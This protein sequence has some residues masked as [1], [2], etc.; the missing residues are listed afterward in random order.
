MLQ[1]NGVC[2]DYSKSKVERF[3]RRSV[4]TINRS[5]SSTATRRCH[6]WLAAQ[7]WREQLNP[8]FSSEL[9]CRGSRVFAGRVCRA[10][11]DCSCRCQL[12]VNSSATS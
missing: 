2:K 10:H 3:L 7:N 1:S 12:P 8:W 9:I 4:V 5:V 11:G 6:W